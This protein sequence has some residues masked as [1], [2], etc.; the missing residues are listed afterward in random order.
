MTSKEIIQDSIKSQRKIL[1][2]NMNCFSREMRL[3][4][5]NEIIMYYQVLKDLEI[6]E[7]L[8]KVLNA[9]FLYLIKNE[10]E[11]EKVKEWLENEK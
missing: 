10:E 7:I 8:K 5:E 2:D 4:Y 11:Q 3:L 1:F 6:L 9:S